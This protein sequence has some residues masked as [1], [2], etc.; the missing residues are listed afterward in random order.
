VPDRDIRGRVDGFLRARVISGGLAAIGFASWALFEP[1]PLA[2]YLF[3]GAALFAASSLVQLRRPFTRSSNAVLVDAAI[4]F[5]TI[6]LAR[7]FP[8]SEATALALVMTSA[9]VF[10]TGRAGRWVLPVLATVAAGIGVVNW[11]L[12]A[13]PGWSSTGMVVNA[14]VAM[15][16]VFPL[17]VWMSGFVARASEQGL[18]SLIGVDDPATFA[19]AVTETASEGIAVI[20]M[21]SVLRYANPAFCAIF[22]YQPEE[23]IGSSLAAV[24]DDDTFRRHDE[25]VVEAMTSGRVIDVL[26]LELVGRHRAGHPVTVLVSLSE[27]AAEGEP[28][29]L[30]AVR[31]VSEMVELRARL[32]RLVAAKDEFVATVSHE[33]RTPLT[34]VVAYSE[35]LQ[36]RTGLDPAEEQEFIDLVADQAREVSYLI[37]DLLVAAR[38]ESES[39][40]LALRPTQLM[41]EVVSSTAPW[42]IHR[43]LDV[44]HASLDHLVRVDPGR[45]RQIIRNLIS[46]AVKYGGDEIGV[47]AEIHHDGMCH[48]IVGDNGPGVAPDR[49]DAVF[50]MYEHSRDVEGQ[51]SSVGLGL[52]VSRR[53]AEMMGGSLCYRRREDKTEFV[54]TVPLADERR[55]PSEAGR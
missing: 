30:G 39:V 21:D 6:L 40:S 43:S 4:V 16:A 10:G 45:L 53:L 32:Q 23:L 36:D 50:D 7:P 44:D 13:P 9:V 48:V 42:V 41:T 31:D 33:L 5:G 52:Y 29:V 2:W 46:N 11:V 14:V 55:V 12:R 54:V 37:E 38:I 26:N 18:I 47:S 3:G 24:M 22:G 51:P 1:E 15:G 19:N 35:M 17:I 20:G 25:A 27:L 49:E 34:A 28:L 8:G